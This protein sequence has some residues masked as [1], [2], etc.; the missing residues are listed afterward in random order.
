M[1]LNVHQVIDAQGT[2]I[3]NVY[4]S[5]TDWH[6]YWIPSVRS[7]DAR[8]MDMVRRTVKPY[9][10]IPVLDSEGKRIPNLVIRR[11]DSGW[12]YYLSC[13]IHGTRYLR[14][15]PY[16][17]LVNARKWAR[18][19]IKLHRERHPNLVTQKERRDRLANYPISGLLKMYES[20]AAIQ[21]A[22]DGKPS[23]RTVH[24]N[25]VQLENVISKALDIPSESVGRQ[26]ITVLTT[27]LAES[28]IAKTVAAVQGENHILKHRARVTAASTLRQAKS[29][30]AKWAM[31]HY[32]RR[33]TLP[34]S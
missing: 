15:I 12:I 16:V 31:A 6:L 32:T 24:Q 2:T 22:V 18:Q 4:C 5:A 33:L 19:F 10:C 7:V 9:Q 11:M 1:V 25:A 34:E 20:V 14:A 30:F 8:H 21:R 17:H 13:Q 23:E 28:Y 3:P 27:E 26:S 29:V